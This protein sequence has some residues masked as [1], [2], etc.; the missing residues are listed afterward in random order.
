MVDVGLALSLPLLILLLWALVA[1]VR[2]SKK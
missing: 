2:D 1:L